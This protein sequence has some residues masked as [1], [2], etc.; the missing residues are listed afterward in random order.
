MARLSS[1]ALRRGLD[2]LELFVNGPTELTVPEIVRQLQLPRTSAH[3]L[4]TTLIDRGY[5]RPVGEPTSN[6]F[7]LGVRTLELGNAYETG[8]DL[9]R[10]GKQIATKLSARCNET[11]QLGILSGSDVVYIAKVESS[12]P[13][14]LVSDVGR[15]LPAHCTAI[16]K[17]LLAGLTDDEVTALYPNEKLPKITRCSIGDLGELRR[18]LNLVR[19]RGWAIDANESSE[20]LA[21]VGSQVY[22]RSKTVRAAMSISVP[23]TRWD[24]ERSAQLASMVVDATSELATILGY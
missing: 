23:T 18:E 5:L 24:D 14:R 22:D 8:L 11:V 6:R 3:E 9:V 15:R 12:R 17:A 19:E 21:C 20:G 4:V 1:P 7:S 13:V 10:E 2:V 16:G